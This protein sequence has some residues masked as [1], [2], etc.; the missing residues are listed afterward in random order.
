MR[1]AN[2]ML[3]ENLVNCGQEI[4]DLRDQIEGLKKEQKVQD[5]SN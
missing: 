4:E 2:A 5:N 1:D 3:L